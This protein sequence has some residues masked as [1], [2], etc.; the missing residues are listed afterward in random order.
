M[1]E[2]KTAKGVQD[3][4]IFGVRRAIGFYT[5][6]HCELID[7]GTFHALLCEIKDVVNCVVYVIDEMID[8]LVLA[9]NDKK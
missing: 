2:Y 6:E 3:R 4:K 7:C 5:L 9:D 8:K 1:Q